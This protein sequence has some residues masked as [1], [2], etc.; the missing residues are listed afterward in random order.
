[1]AAEAFD[2]DEWL[3]GYKPVTAEVRL[4]PAELLDEHEALD[5]ELNSNPGPARSIELAAEIVALEERAVTAVRVFT[6]R[7]LSALAWADLISKHPPTSEQVEKDPGAGHNP[8]TFIPAAMAAA[9]LEPRLSV[10]QC[11]RIHGTVSYAQ[12]DLLW[13]GVIRANLGVM[14][15]FPKS[16]LAAGIRH[17]SNG[18]SGTTAPPGGSPAASSFAGGQTTS[19]RPSSGKPR[20][21]ASAPAAANRATRRSQ[22]SASSK[23]A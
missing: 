23:R 18:R 4:W 22:K 8:D 7:N 13:G 6:F 9:S 5:L 19:G 12:W 21:T 16:A 1:V 11:E 2:V 3:A 15:A 10:A 17:L 20:K 14:D